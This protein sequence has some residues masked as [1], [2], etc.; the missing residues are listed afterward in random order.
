MVVAQSSND[1]ETVL[2]VT[3]SLMGVKWI[4]DT[5]AAFHIS[6]SRDLF[7]SY[8]TCTGLALMGNDHACRVVGIG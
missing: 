2:I 3:D 8:E 7:S 6:I 1:A 4:L 5:A